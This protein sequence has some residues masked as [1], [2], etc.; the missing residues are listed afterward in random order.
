M[1]IGKQLTYH[2]F[3]DINPMYYKNLKW[4]IEN[5]MTEQDFFFTYEHEN[6]EGKE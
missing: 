2:D 4:V 1:A 5:D 6:L 3:E